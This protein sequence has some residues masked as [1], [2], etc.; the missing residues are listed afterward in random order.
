MFSY[1]SNFYDFI[2]IIFKYLAFGILNWIVLGKY[3]IEDNV[4]I[5]SHAW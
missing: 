5:F 1:T 2:G 3:P 4:Q